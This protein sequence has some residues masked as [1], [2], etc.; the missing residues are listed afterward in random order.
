VISKKNIFYRFSGRSRAFYETNTDFFEKKNSVALPS[1]VRGCPNEKIGSKVQ[2]KA[3]RAQKR[4]FLVMKFRV[5]YSLIRN[6]ML[7]SKPILYGVWNA[8]GNH[9]RPKTWN[10]NLLIDQKFFI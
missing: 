4:N 9:E 1:A 8:T 2:Y 10:S 5:T 7:R 6:F 3:M